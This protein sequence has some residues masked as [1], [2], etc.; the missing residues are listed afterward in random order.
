MDVARRRGLG[1][2]RKARQ[3][4]VGAL[5]D[6][7]APSQLGPAPRP[8]ERHLRGGAALQE[9]LSLPWCPGD[10]LTDAP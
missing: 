5:G 9:G 3:V 4:W 1:W 6:P 10:P 2:Q 7:E 8:A